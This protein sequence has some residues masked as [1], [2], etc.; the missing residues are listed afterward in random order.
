M[1]FSARE[2][3]IRTLDGEEVVTVP[4]GVVH[5]ETIRIRGKGVPTARGSRGDLLV[6]VD[7]EFPK[8]LSRYGARPNR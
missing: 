5:G 2:Y 7:I 8:K 6:R 1:H 4:A 3:R